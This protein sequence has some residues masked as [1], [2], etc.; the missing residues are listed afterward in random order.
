MNT[1]ILMVISAFALAGL[2]SNSYV[3]A[4]TEKL[5]EIMTESYQNADM[6][7]EMTKAITACT[8]GMKA[9]DTTVIDP[10]G[11]II[12]NTN[13]HLKNLLS[14]SKVDI[15]AVV[16]KYGYDSGLDVGSLY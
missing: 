16:S 13:T 15:D 8:T 2:F 10:C 1:K 7:R 3:Y 4:Q 5:G 9:F 12:S 11:N 14:E 6:I